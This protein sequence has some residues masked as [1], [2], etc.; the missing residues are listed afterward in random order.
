MPLLKQRKLEK[1]S[2]KENYFNGRP[3]H[4][5]FIIYH[6]TPLFGFS[7]NTNPLPTLIRPSSNMRMFFSLNP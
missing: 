6:A 3:I 2:P 7:L 5:E 4:L 1:A